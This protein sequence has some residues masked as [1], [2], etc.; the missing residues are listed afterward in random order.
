MSKGMPWCLLLLWL[1]APL[2]ADNWPTWRGPDGQG[3][4]TE[5]NLPLRWGP[6]DNVRWK[7][8]LPDRGNSTPIVWGERL[9]LT[10]AVGAAAPSRRMVLCF[11]RKNG[12]LLWQKE[13]LYSEPEPTHETNPYCSAS[14]VTDGE[15]VIASLGS[16]GM[17]CYDFAGRE[18]WRKSLGKLEQIWGNASSP[19][20]YGDLAILWCGPGERQFLLA[21]DK[22]TGR[23][24]WQHDEPGGNSGKNGDWIGSWSTPIITRI[25]GREQ[26][27]L[28]VPQKLKGFDPL[29]GKELWSCPGLGKLVYTSP[30]CSND[31]T[32]M[33]LSG[34]HGPALGIHLDGLGNVT[35]V[36]QHAEKQPQRIGSPV[37]VGPSAYILN[38]DGSAECFNIKTGKSLW[39]KERVSGSAWGSMVA[40]GDRLY[41]TNSA[42]ETLILKAGPR[43]ELV[44]KNSIAEPVFASLAISNGELF[45]RS[46]QH[47]WCI[48]IMK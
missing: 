48:S 23:T 22:N 46:H 5:T 19:I 45:L 10:Q 43:Y 26:L 39:K 9:F 12:E 8:P 2:K 31:G 18:L 28:P 24:V 47:L 29:T 38:D 1:A 33:A 36:W 14:P 37:I 30:V 13:T 42:G 34:F 41:V 25:G 3:H 32:V 21:V 20:L 17:V 16:A 11:D 15:H 27:I 35:R 7:V 4:T 6:S 44:A 40:A